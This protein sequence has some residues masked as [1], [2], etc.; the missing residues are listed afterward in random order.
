MINEK[1]GTEMLEKV[2]QFF[3][4]VSVETKSFNIKYNDTPTNRRIH[5]LF[6]EYCNRETDNGYLMGIKKLLETASADWKYEMLKQRID[7]LE[8]KQISTEPTTTTTTKKKHKT[9][10]EKDGSNNE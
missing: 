3:K 6:K 2:D 8:G 5:E 7:E 1:N 4:T 10:G 9:F